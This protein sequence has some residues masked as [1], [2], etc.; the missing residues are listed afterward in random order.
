MKNI[1]LLEKVAKL[2]G[3]TFSSEKTTT[4]TFAQAELEGGV[5]ITNSTDGEF[6]VGD[7][8]SLVNEDG[9]TSVVGA[10]EHKLMDGRLFITDAE[11]KLTEIKDITS[12]EPESEVEV[13]EAS[14]EEMESTKIEELKKAIHDVL[15]AF[16]AQSKLIEDLKADYEEFKK[17][18]SHAPLKED[19]LVSKN[20]TDARYEILKAMKQNK[21]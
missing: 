12:E 3:F 15:F 19:K 20:F 1:E 8:I 5:N 2:V 6:V 10:G 11:G 13:E 17:S 14:S 4:E 16:E 21:K 7:T 18:A 9:T